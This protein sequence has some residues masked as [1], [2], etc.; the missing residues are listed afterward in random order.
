MS[1]GKLEGYV[2]QLHD[3]QSHDHVCGNF[4][5]P[6]GFAHALHY[7][8]HVRRRLQQL[9]GEFVEVIGGAAHFVQHARGID[10]RGRRPFAVPQIEFGLAGSPPRASRRIVVHA[11]P[12]LLRGA[13][14][15][16]LHQCLDRVAG[17]GIESR[18]RH[19]S[20]KQDALMIGPGGNPGQVTE[21][22]ADIC[23]KTN[24]TTMQ[25]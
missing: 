24:W 8:S 14:T 5:P 17:L 10:Q 1:G 2:E 15:E 3:G 16:K 22:Q 7:F 18:S 9:V 13:G 11:L 19:S 20:N 6:A 4:H 21:D 23:S 25:G 12:D